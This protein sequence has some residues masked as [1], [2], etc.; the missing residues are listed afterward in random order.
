MVQLHCF[1]S[2]AHWIGSILCL[3]CAS[4]AHMGELLRKHHRNIMKAQSDIRRMLRNYNISMSFDAFWYSRCTPYYNLLI[5]HNQR[6]VW[7]GLLIWP[8]TE[9]W[10]AMNAALKRFMCLAMNRLAHVR[11]RKQ[12]DFFLNVL[13]F[14]FH[15]LNSRKRMDFFN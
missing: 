2:E 11:E 9:K 4:V 10:E 7:K 1:I 3:L 13:R 8:T 6:G 14:V 15:Q 12:C 5:V